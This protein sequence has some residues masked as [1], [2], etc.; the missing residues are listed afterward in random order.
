MSEKTIERA[1]KAI[2]EQ[3]NCILLKLFP[4]SAAGV[5]DRLLLLPGGDCCFIELKAESGRMSAIQRHWQDKL[6]RKGFKA[7]TVYSVNQFQALLD[8]LLASP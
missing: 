8:T 1:C 7:H 5:P 2:A 4:G 3:N 6:R